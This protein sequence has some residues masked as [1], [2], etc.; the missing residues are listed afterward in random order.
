MLDRFHLTDEF[1][2]LL[3]QACELK[4]IDAADAFALGANFAREGEVADMARID[5]AAAADYIMECAHANRHGALGAAKHAA[6]CALNDARV[7]AS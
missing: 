1:R 5:E 3:I 6:L 2:E 7:G 4:V